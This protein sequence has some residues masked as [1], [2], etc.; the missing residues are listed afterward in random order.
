MGSK[1]ACWCTKKAAG[2]APRV[3][4]NGFSK[5]ILLSVPVHRLERPIV[6]QPITVIAELVVV[7]E[8]M[9]IGVMK[10]NVRDSEADEVEVEEE[11]AM[12]PRMLE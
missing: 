12:V 11:A 5:P 7:V 3:F 6:R 4:F 10:E 2:S 1:A 9:I 8:K